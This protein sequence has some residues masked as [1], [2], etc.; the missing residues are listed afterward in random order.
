MGIGCCLLKLFYVRFIS[1]SLITMPS[2]YLI[3]LILVV[4][5]IYKLCLIPHSF[6]SSRTIQVRRNIYDSTE[7]IGLKGYDVQNTSF[8]Q[9][10][11][12]VK[13][14]TFFDYLLLTDNGEN[15]L[16]VI[17]TA[18]AAAG[19]A[20]YFYQFE[21]DE[22]FSKKKFRW[23]WC[24]IFLLYIA[25]FASFEGGTYTRDF[26]NSL[27]VSKGGKDDWNYNYYA[28]RNTITYFIPVVFI[29]VAAL[30]RELIKHFNKKPGDLLDGD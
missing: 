9:Y 10:D 29:T 5:A 19:S 26:W 6:S 12:Q 17:L 23:V 4:F 27:Y 3:L 21:L 1:Q 15:L 20:W 11:I 7:L 24:G 30:Y 16:S 13:P 18:A 22:I 2:K 14:I 25:Y 28:D 8:E